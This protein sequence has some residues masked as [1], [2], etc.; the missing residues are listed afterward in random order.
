[1]QDTKIPTHS[2]VTR[3][4]DGNTE[5]MVDGFSVLMFIIE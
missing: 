1:M 4:H 2:V 5:P 3:Y